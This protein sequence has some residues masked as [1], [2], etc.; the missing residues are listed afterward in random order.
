M[1]AFS[2]TLAYMVLAMGLTA[3]VYGAPLGGVLLIAAGILFMP[4]FRRRVIYVPSRVA[5]PV[6]LGL[7]ALGLASLPAA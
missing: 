4:R 7:A 3:V 6:A 5:V 2:N 1:A